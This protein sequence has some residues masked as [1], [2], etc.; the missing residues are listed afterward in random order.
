MK[1]FIKLSLAFLCT[2]FLFSCANF[3]TADDLAPVSL[4]ITPAAERTVFAPVT[5]S[6]FTDIKW[7]YKKSNSTDEYTLLAEY[8]NVSE[9]TTKEYLVPGTYD[10]EVTANVSGFIYYAETKNETVSKAI[11]NSV[12][13]EMEL[14]SKDTFTGNG[15]FSIVLNIL[16]KRLSKYAEYSF[17][18]DGVA[19]EGFTNRE[20]TVVAE[21]LQDKT[22]VTAATQGTETI[23]A[24]MYDFVI[25]VYTSANKNF[26]VASSKNVIQIVNGKKS[27]GAFSPDFL[28]LS[29]HY[30]SGVVCDNVS[31]ERLGDKLC[32]YGTGVIQNTIENGGVE[33]WS[34]FIDDISEIIVQDG[35][36]AFDT[37][38]SIY[39]AYIT[40]LTG[41][42][43]FEE[44]NSAFVN[45][46]NIRFVNGF[47]KLKHGIEFVVGMDIEIVNGF[48]EL[49]EIPE[50]CFNDAIDLVS[51]EG[52]DSLKKIGSRAFFSCE[53]LTKIPE[54]ANVTEICE[55]AFYECN[56]LKKL[57][58]FGK[59]TTIGSNAFN[60][61]TEIKELN[62]FNSVTFIA[63]SA[64]YNC[65]GI[66]TVTGFNALESS[67]SHFFQG[68]V[69]KKV[70]GFNKLQSINEGFFGDVKFLESLKGFAQITLIENYAFNRQIFL[71]EIP[72]RFYS[73]EVEVALDAFYQTKFDRDFNH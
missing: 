39:D 6:D 70:N 16:E 34:S 51:L 33:P 50:D 59:V 73:E 36:T 32:F 41:F 35:I 49:E 63:D 29:S 18:K 58:A 44:I 21:T 9:T 30:N 46:D 52:F 40:T 62:G 3:N 53:F 56:S 72:E 67:D 23:P 28:N 54:F 48:A 42:N 65:V 2:V 24:G 8:Q 68:C 17:Y 4:V 60:N 20:C 38:D 69:I 10:F 26:C 15:T 64:F 14:Y 43:S 1:K 37:F 19:V 45:A 27:E 13:M 7:S 57:P 22:K 5:T 47:N 11:P 66:E 71:E 61:C 31:Y 55:Y 25:N 12:R